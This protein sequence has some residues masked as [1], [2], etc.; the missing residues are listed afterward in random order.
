MSHGDDLKDSASPTRKVHTRKKNSRKV[1]SL[2]R[3]EDWVSHVPSSLALTIINNIQVFQP[4][5]PDRREFWLGRFCSCQCSASGAF[6]TWWV[7]GLANVSPSSYQDFDDGKVILHISLPAHFPADEVRMRNILSR[8]AK[9]T[10]SISDRTLFRVRR[11][12][13]WVSGMKCSSS[14]VSW[15]LS[16]IY[17]R[18]RESTAFLETQQQNIAF[19][20]C[21]E[22]NERIEV[23][24][25]RSRL[26]ACFISDG[27]F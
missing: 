8:P 23:H 14:Q 10:S 20:V 11:I 9:A 22:K 15:Y 26:G 1:C 19:C 4:F 25:C 18:H 21:V 12:G 3:M 2:S 7:Y 27:V 13:I 24:K 6:I 5:N 16:G 17:V